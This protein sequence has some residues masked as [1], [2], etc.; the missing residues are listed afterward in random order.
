MMWLLC[1]ATPGGKGAAVETCLRQLHDK[2]QVLQQGMVLH[3]LKNVIKVGI[4]KIMRKRE[5]NVT[6]EVSL[7]Y[8]P[9]EQILPPE[10]FLPHPHIIHSTDFCAISCASD[11]YNIK[12]MNHSAFLFWKMSSSLR[13]LFTQNS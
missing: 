5:R 13:V 11:E 2:G 3:F 7:M 10:G 9:C 1:C 6:R 12:G 8:L 4:L